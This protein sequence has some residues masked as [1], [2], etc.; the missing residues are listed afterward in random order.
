MINDITL[1]GERIPFPDKITENY[2][3]IENVY[4]T[5][6]GT[7]QIAVTRAEKLTL[8]L[9]FSLSSAWAQKMRVLAK[10]NSLTAVIDEAGE[11]KTRTMRIRDYKSDMVENS[12]YTPGTS[13]LWNVSFSLI[14]F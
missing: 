11:T 7:D 1:D 10:K 12:R 6:A 14:E 5:E 4:Q 13:G 9:S 3:V 8:G 2:E